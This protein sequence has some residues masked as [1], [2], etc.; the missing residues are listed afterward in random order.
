MS[1]IGVVAGKYYS[2]VTV[3]WAG[4][5]VTDR[6]PRTRSLVESTEPAYPNRLY[7]HG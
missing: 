3:V 7:Y 5:K 2:T 6:Q 4:K 1:G